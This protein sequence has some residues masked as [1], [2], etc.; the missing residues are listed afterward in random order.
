[1]L[2]QQEIGVNP[3]FVNGPRSRP[4]GLSR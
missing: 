1:L 3:D 4:I 2:R